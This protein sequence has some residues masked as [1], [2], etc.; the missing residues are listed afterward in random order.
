DRD[1]ALHARRAADPRAVRVPR[2][3]RLRPLRGLPRRARARR[4]RRRS[5]GDRPDVRARGPDER[6]RRAAPR[7]PPRRRH[8]VH[9]ADGL[10]DVFYL[11]KPRRYLNVGIYLDDSPIEKGGVR[12]IPFSHKQGIWPLLTR[13]R[14]YLDT[15]ADPD[16]YGIVAKAGDLTIHDGRIWH[17]VAQ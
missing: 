15:S 12:L 4:D 7:R 8:R 6:L 1:A 17:R 5:R 10:R 3:L 16:E 9:P 13:K 11:E 14:Y 2:H